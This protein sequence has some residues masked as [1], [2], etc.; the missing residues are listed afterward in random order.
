MYSTHAIDRKTCFVL[1][2]RGRYVSFGFYKTKTYGLTTER[3]AMTNILLPLCM[4]PCCFFH[5]KLFWFFFFVL[6][7]TLRSLNYNRNGPAC[8]RV[9]ASFEKSYF[10]LCLFVSDTV[11][12]IRTTQKSVSERDYDLRRIST[13]VYI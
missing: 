12:V 3:T 10:G 4:V 13:D 5:A 9:Y 1:R 6:F 2:Q 8:A 7:T 11:N